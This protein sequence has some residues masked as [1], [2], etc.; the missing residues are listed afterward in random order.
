MRER[1]TLFLFIFTTIIF[2]V[3]LSFYLVSRSALREHVADIPPSQPPSP[4]AET[5]FSNSYINLPVSIPMGLLEQELKGAVPNQFSTRSSKQSGRF[6]G[7]RF[8]TY[9]EGAT[10]KVNHIDIAP[11][12]Q[13]ISALIRAADPTIRVQIK[14][15]DCRGGP[16]GF[17]VNVGVD[18]SVRIK[19]GISA[20]TDWKLK[21]E[22]L[23]V[24]FTVSEALVKIPIWP[25]PL[26]ISD[27]LEKELRS[28]IERDI[29]SELRSAVGNIRTHRTY[30]RNIWNELCRTEV[31]DPELG[32]EMRISPKRAYVERP[33]FS[34]KNLAI[35]VGLEFQTRAGI[36]ISEQQAAQECPFPSSIGSRVP[37]HPGFSIAVPADVTYSNLESILASVLV[38]TAFE[39]SPPVSISVRDIG[40]DGYGSSILLKLELEGMVENG[41]FKW[42]DRRIRGTV[43]LA[44]VPELDAEDQTITFHDIQLDTSSK[45]VLVDLAGEALEP[46]L[47][48]RLREH[49]VVNLDAVLEKRKD[50]LEAGLATL[51]SSGQLNASL[52][53][54]TLSD[55][56]VGPEGIRV[57]MQVDGGLNLNLK[58]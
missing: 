50:D 13:R 39:V 15:G 18:F 52:R 27:K 14:R 5:P 29:K 4:L 11:E 36:A 44:A 38:G 34:S 2:I 26:D 49:A 58:G 16:S 30:A 12:G 31:L 9:T 7:I 45:N 43:Y 56:Q 21:L 33:K 55:L 22:D 54:F 23:Y 25:R 19:S 20:S 40:L 6:L 48:S 3:G 8:C 10:F 17:K 37:G 51:T 46:M 53:E 47:L 1:R 57:L 28:G 41:W 42:F 35:N 32:L 24:R